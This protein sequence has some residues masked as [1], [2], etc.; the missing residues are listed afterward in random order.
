MPG[1]EKP[2]NHRPTP[3]LATAVPVAAPVEDAPTAAGTPS[4]PSPTMLPAIS[5]PTGVP[6]ISPTLLSFTPSIEPSQMPTNS[7][8]AS[9]EPSRIDSSET[10]SVFTC[11]GNGVTFATPPFQAERI[12][13][14]VGYEVESSLSVEDIRVDL[15]KLI[16]GSIL[17]GALECGTLDVEGNAPTNT[18][19]TDSLCV[20]EVDLLN[21]CAVLQ[22]STTVLLASEN[23]DPQIARFLAYVK[24]E[25]DMETFHEV[26][27]GVDRVTYISPTIFRPPGISAPVD[28]DEPA[29]LQ[30]N[31]T[32]LAATPW[33][34]GAA[35]AMCKFNNCFYRV[36]N[37]F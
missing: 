24:L 13:I 5:T 17:T 7:P 35:L 31:D 18:S 26:L 14:T 15:E 22:T 10:A 1:V 9:F 4:H 19:V 33:T 12:D 23:F 29:S 21:D 34:V 27:D 16:L 25:R 37:R 28:P 32:R 36:S 2:T 11:T 20:P 8:T 6:S 30:S 3:T